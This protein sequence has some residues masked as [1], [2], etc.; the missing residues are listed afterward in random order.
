MSSRTP[1]IDTKVIHA[2]QRPDPSTGAVMPPIYATSTYTQSSPG[3]HSGFE[4]SRP[5]NPTRYALERMVASL[6]SSSLTEEQDVTR[7]G[8]A[9]ASGLA[10]IATLLELFDAGTRIVAMDDLYGGTNRLFSRVRA[11]TQNL[12]IHYADLSNLDAFGKVMTPDTKLVWV[13]TP[14]NPLLKLADLSAVAAHAKRVNP[15]VLVACDNTF[16]SPILQRPLEHG[17]DIVMHST[18][19]YLNGHSDSIGGLAVVTDAAVAEKLR[20]HQNALGAIMSP[21]EAYFVLRG[22]K[23]LA[24]R[25]QRHSE[26]GQRIAEHLARHEMVR[27]AIY[28]GLTTHPQ[29]DLAKRQMPDG[30]G[31]MV[32]FYI[33]GGAEAARV[34]L[35]NVR[36]F[37]LAES[38]GGVESLVNH[39]VIMTHASVPAEQ[40]QA[41]GITEDLIRLS[42][43]IEDCDDLIG[44]IDQALAA[45]A[46][47][48][49]VKV[50]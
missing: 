30:F 3:V 29:H 13:E 40:R 2:G 26:S 28:P 34:F 39:P 47:V 45:A 36:I 1:K 38:L 43:G 42:V 20:F 9:F 16:S 19:K 15:D 7:G 46:A 33:E 17:F 18:T 22:V 27:E 12:D 25:M 50:S 21:F 37:A 10:C 35:E 24:L 11:R 23:T 49:K 31:G 41:L 48:A 4:Y 5:H 6:E 32:S 8:F 14:T 44:D